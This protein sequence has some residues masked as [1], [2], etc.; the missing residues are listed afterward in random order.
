MAVEIVDRYHKTNPV[1][2]AG[3]LCNSE[4]GWTLLTVVGTAGGFILGQMFNAL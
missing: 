4:S 1:S 2:L 3:V